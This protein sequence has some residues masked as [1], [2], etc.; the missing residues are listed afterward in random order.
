MNRESFRQRIT[1][2]LR[3]VDVR[4]LNVLMT[5]YGLA[6]TGHIDMKERAFGSR[7]EK[8]TVRQSDPPGRQSESDPA[9]RQTV[10]QSDC[11]TA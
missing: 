11:L 6:H 2:L 3:G 8:Q 9:G 7:N 4:Q 1:S 10:R 5:V